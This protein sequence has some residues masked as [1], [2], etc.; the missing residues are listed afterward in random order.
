MGPALTPTELTPTVPSAT[1]P[2]VEVLLDVWDPSFRRPAFLADAIDSL[3]REFG[4]PAERFGVYVLD[5]LD[6]RSALGRAVE[7]ER[8]TEAFDNDADYLRDMYADHEDLGLTSLIC[9]VDHERRVPVGVMRLIRNT[10]EHWSPTLRDL[11]HDGENGWAMTWDEFVAKASLVGPSV[12]G[13]VDVA[14]FAVA[15]EYASGYRVDG[16]SGAICAAMFQRFVAW[17]TEIMICLFEEVP[18]IMVQAF[19]A[20]FC[21]R[22]EGVDAQPYHGAPATV[23]VWSNPRRHERHLCDEHPE[24]YRRFMRFEGLEE[25]FFAFPDGP[26]RWDPLTEEELARLGADDKNSQVIDLRDGAQDRIRTSNSS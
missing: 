15:R 23:P 6:P 12:D 17:Q 26:S 3:H 11:L 16:V 13:I 8:F 14:T 4:A 5:G 18:L 20:D 2:E 9:A 22:F 21:R 19:T 25:Y 10:P 24:I 7:L 1:R